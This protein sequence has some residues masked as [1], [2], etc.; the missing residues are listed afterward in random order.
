MVARIEKVEDEQKNTQK[1]AN[2]ALAKANAACR[3]VS[4]A[5]KRVEA[6]E[7]SRNGGHHAV[8]TKLSLDEVLR[9]EVKH[10]RNLVNEA[11]NHLATVVVGYHKSTGL[12]RM[13]KESL[14]S[15]VAARTS[16]DYC[17]IDTRGRVG[18]IHF[19]QREQRSGDVRARDFIRRLEEDEEAS[20]VWARIK[21]P[22]EHRRAEGLARSFGKF[23]SQSFP[24]DNQPR[25]RCLD[26]YLV[27][28][29]VVIAPVTMFQT[30]ASFTQLRKAVTAVLYN[31]NRTGLDINTPLFKQLRHSIVVVL[32]NFYDS[33]NFL[34][35]GDGREPERSGKRLSSNREPNKERNKEDKV[36]VDVMDQGEG[37][38]KTAP[39]VGG[40]LKPARLPSPK[41]HHGP[42]SANNKFVTSSKR[43]ATAPQGFR[44]YSKRSRGRARDL[45]PTFIVD[46]VMS[47]TWPTE[48]HVH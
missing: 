9:V 2:V 18:L 19:Q 28:D 21:R 1:D 3:A 15:F 30:A 44:S 38:E 47:L 27:V 17:S 26:G 10:V 14:A 36:F 7:N 35:D 41:P 13:D 37:A 6:L 23:L 22:E 24:S 48:F 33:V 43:G 11:K 31:D 34:F 45:S 12:E 46:P 20:S 5:L 4:D 8:P 16:A 42:A 40:L 32:Y 29:N 39:P 25:T